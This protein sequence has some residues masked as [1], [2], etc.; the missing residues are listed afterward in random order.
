[1]AEH[2]RRRDPVPDRFRCPH[3]TVFAVIAGPRSRRG[4]EQSCGHNGRESGA[5]LQ[6]GTPTSYNLHM[7]KST[8]HRHLEA[9]SGQTASF[10][11]S[12]KE[13]GAVQSL[14]VSE[15]LSTQSLTSR[16]IRTSGLVR[17]SCDRAGDEPGPADRAPH[18]RPRLHITTVRHVF[19]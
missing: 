9:Q 6:G 3:I 15:R 17:R 18:Q 19:R 8:F 5:D 7:D 16:T 1:M 13:T 12:H 10:R 2:Y 4:A 11:A 14:E